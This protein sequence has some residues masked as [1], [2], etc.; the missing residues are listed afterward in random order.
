M[1]SR[2][3]G[4][5]P[6]AQRPPA[7]RG[8]GAR[9]LP[10]TTDGGHRHPQANPVSPRRVNDHEPRHVSEALAELID[11]LAERYGIDPAKLAAP[12]LGALRRAEADRGAER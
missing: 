4:R 1:T 5:D 8:T 7:G 11:E 10:E 9:S 12:T 3:K 2:P 6:D